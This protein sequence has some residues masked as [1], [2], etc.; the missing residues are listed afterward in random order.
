MQA[1]SRQERKGALISQNRKGNFLLTQ[2]FLYHFIPQMIQRLIQ[3]KGVHGC[4]GGTADFPVRET[5]IQKKP[6]YF[7]R[8]EVQA[9]SGEQGCDIISG[10]TENKAKGTGRP[11]SADQTE[12]YRPEEAPAERGRM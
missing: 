3:G 7:L 11:A 8:T 5:D 2:E 4:S 1:V 6:G 9:A 12:K 10:K